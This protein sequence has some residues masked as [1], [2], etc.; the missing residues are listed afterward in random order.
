MYGSEKTR[1]ML[2]IELSK[3]LFFT[4]LF[5][6]FFC[7]ILW[8]KKTFS[9]L[10]LWN[11]LSNLESDCRESCVFCFLHQISYRLFSCMLIKNSLKST[12]TAHIWDHSLVSVI[13]KVIFGNPYLPGLHRGVRNGEASTRQDFWLPGVDCIW[14]KTNNLCIIGLLQKI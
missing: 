10:V 12:P 7:F 5:I 2:N 1:N 14:K 11:L 4:F 3:F 8:Y 9:V 6:V 13:E